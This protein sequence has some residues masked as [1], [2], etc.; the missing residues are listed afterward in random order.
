[1]TTNEALDLLK[2]VAA[3]TPVQDYATRVQLLKSIA[4]IEQ[5]LTPCDSDPETQ[6]ERKP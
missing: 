5:A 4:V 1:M 3:I 2:Q 6:Q